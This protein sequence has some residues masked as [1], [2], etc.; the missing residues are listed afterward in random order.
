MAVPGPDLELIGALSL[1][2]ILGLTWV[3]LG[4]DWASGFNVGC[5]SIPFQVRG[6][7][8]FKGN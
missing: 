4:T 3:R 5:A 7:L 2:I 8:R 1:Q 6:C